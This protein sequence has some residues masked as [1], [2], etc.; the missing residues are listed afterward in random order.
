MN[1]ILAKKILEN[2][3]IKVVEA[4]DGKDLLE[5]YRNS[6]NGGKSE[7]DLILTDAN[8]PPFNGDKATEEIRKI[9][10]MNNIDQNNEIPI[11]ALSGEGN[12]ENIYH[13]FNSYMTDYFIKGCGT[14]LLLKVIANY[15][16]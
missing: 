7:F 2:H 6:L 4:K 10:V 8:M 1:R 9:E 16:K 5:I 3:E 14:E 12:K 15:T 11:I 13:F